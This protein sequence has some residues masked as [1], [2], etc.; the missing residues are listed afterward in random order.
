MS[1]EKI[2]QYKKEKASRKA[3][4]K[5]EK[6]K[7]TIARVSL[8]AGGIVVVAFLVWG[9][10]ATV[11]DGGLKKITNKQDQNQIN[12]QV[13]QELLEYL[14]SNADSAPSKQTE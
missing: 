2:N 6:T 14:N 9:I 10:I 1:Q 12:Q 3:K 4:M 8:I 11:Q 5:K 13:S 7:K